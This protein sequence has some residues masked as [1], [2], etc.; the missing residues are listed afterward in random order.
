MTSFKEIIKFI[1]EHRLNDPALLAYC[2]SAWRKP[3][4]VKKTLRKRTEISTSEMPL[5]QITRPEILSDQENN[6]A[7][8]RE[9]TVSLYCLFHQPNVDLA[10]DEIIEFEEMI[11]L[12]MLGPDRTFG[13]LIDHIDPGS[14]A[15]DEGR[16][17]PVYCIVKQYRVKRE[18]VYS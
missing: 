14:S 5:I 12:A 4:R 18:E 6:I 15:N 13:E 16:F 9:H 3:L 2:Q 7:Y 11:D 10:F 8:E 1:I 17:H